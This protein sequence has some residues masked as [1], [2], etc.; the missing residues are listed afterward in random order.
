MSGRLRT[1]SKG[2]FGM[3][4]IEEKADLYIKFGWWKTVNGWIN[5]VK[6]GYI[7][8]YKEATRWRYPKEE[9]PEDTGDFPFTKYLVMI[10]IFAENYSARTV[11]VSTYECEKWS[12]DRDDKDILE[13]VVVGWRPIEEGGEK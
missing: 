12:T 13:L 6:E 4:T 10:D 5:R 7:Q 9:L 3:K 11:T 8:G 2:V 1:E